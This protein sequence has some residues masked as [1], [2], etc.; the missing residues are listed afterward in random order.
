M[1]LQRPGSSQAH[2]LGKRNQPDSSGTFYNFFEAWLTQAHNHPE[3][4]VHDDVA[5]ILKED[6]WPDPVKL[7][8]GEIPEV[9]LRV[10]SDMTMTQGR[11]ASCGGSFMKFT[12][13]EVVIASSKS[14]VTLWLRLHVSCMQHSSVCGLL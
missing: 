2:H 13:R 11:A 3:P 6:I 14:C 10:Y 8:K 5:D 1:L 4:G 12:Q 9:R 7:Y